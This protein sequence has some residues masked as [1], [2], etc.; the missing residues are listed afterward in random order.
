[1]S[2]CLILPIS[3]PQQSD[4]TGW[5]FGHWTLRN[6][7]KVTGVVRKRPALLTA[8]RQQLEALSD[9]LPQL[10]MIDVHGG[11]RLNHVVPPSDTGPCTKHRHN[12]NDS[13]TMYGQELASGGKVGGRQLAWHMP[14]ALI[15]HNSLDDYQEA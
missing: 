12:H 15:V 10:G 8:L 5:A 4:G 7:P 9:K 13:I 6:T 3:W 1:M 14:Q 2:R 11:A